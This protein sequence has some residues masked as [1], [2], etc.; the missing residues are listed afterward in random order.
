MLCRLSEPL[1][2]WSP[3]PLAGTFPALQPGLSSP[4]WTKYSNSFVKNSPCPTAECARE[5][6]SSNFPIRPHH[7][8]T[9]LTRCVPPL[10]CSLLPASLSVW[11]LLRL[12]SSARLLDLESDGSRCPSNGNS[13]QTSVPEL[14]LGLLCFLPEI[15]LRF[16]FTDKYTWIGHRNFYGGDALRTWHTFNCENHTV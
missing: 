5:R 6:P 14:T 13:C 15:L 8:R 3:Y 11:P 7:Q 9:M 2:S 12:G 4:A 10:C 16:S 1:Q